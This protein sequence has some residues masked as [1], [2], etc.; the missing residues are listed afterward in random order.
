MTSSFVAPHSINQSASNI[1][2]HCWRWH[3]RF[4]GSVV[5]VMPSERKY[6]IEEAVDKVAALV[7]KVQQHCLQLKRGRGLGASCAKCSC[8]KH[9][10]FF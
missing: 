7:G 6:L 5:A 2:I 1:S 3:D 4:L 10:A 8:G 9:K